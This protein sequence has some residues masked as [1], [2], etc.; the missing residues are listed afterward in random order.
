MIIFNKCLAFV[1]DKTFPSCFCLVEGDFNL[2]HPSVLLAAFGKWRGG[3]R[4]VGPEALSIHSQLLISFRFPEYSLKGLLLKLQYFGH[5]MQRADSL[6]KTRCW[7]RLKQ[8]EKG[9]TE[10]EIVR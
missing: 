5:L 8:K 3:A 4:G 1:L 6:E 9:A 7:E 10:H 2:P